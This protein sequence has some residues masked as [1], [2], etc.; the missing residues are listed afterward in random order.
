MRHLC[1]CSSTWNGWDYLIILVSFIKIPRHITWSM[2]VCMLHLCTCYAFI[3]EYINMRKNFA[4]SSLPKFANDTCDHEF[5]E[6]LNFYHRGW[7]TL[8]FYIIYNGNYFIYSSDSCYSL[9]H[10]QEEFLWSVLHIIVK[11]TQIFAR[12]GK[13][14][15]FSPTHLIR[16]APGKLE[17][18]YTVLTFNKSNIFRYI[19]CY[20]LNGKWQT[21]LLKCPEGQFFDASLS[22]CSSLYNCPLWKQTVTEM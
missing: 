1:V 9:L 21:K 17:P 5:N 15:A 22:I 14:K 6:E 19:N 18:I 12:N 20:N 3:Y 7:S 16:I 10:L 13:P 4:F 2:C 11:L 8:L